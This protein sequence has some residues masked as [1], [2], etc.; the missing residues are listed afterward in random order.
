[1]KR[2]QLVIALMILVMGLM[3]YS[4]ARAGDDY[5]STEL[6]KRLGLKKKTG[7]E[8]LEQQRDISRLRLTISSMLNIITA[9]EI[10]STDHKLKYPPSLNALIPKYQRK[11]PGGLSKNGNLEFGYKMRNNG[12]GYQLYVKG[13]KLTY[14]NI[15]ANYPRCTEKDESQ[16]YLKPGVENPPREKPKP[17]GKY[18][19]MWKKE[20]HRLPDLLQSQDPK[21]A[22]EMRINLTKT[23]KSG[24]LNA[25]EIRIANNII[26]S[27]RKIENKKK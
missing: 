17:G 27:C 4:P 2:K 22:K 19:K 10:Y 1:M 9:I 18:R 14:M 15:P 7:M 13:N 25:E 26:K 16:I 24:Y 21:M 20:V 23:I 12:K 3:I 5:Y 8:G 6:L 11:I